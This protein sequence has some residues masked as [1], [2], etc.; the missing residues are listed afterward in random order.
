M[1]LS[2]ILATKGSDVVTIPQTAGIEAAAKVLRDRKFGALMVVDGT[3]K[4]AGIIS[5]RDI[6][7]GLAQSRPGKFGQWDRWIF[8]L[9]AATMP[10][11]RGEYHGK[12]YPPEPHT[13]IQGEGG[14]GRR[15]RRQDAGGVGA[16]V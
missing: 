5:E 1:R 12:A 16:A 2:D 8:C 4:I 6:V 15:E 11:I 14:F 10:R 9:R 13:G 3:G 7:R